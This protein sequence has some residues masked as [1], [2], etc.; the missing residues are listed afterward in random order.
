MLSADFSAPHALAQR[1]T[2]VRAS[3]AADKVRRFF[4]QEGEDVLRLVETFWQRNSC[5][6]DVHHLVSHSHL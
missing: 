6:P 5:L 4:K 3:R 1:Q 2:D